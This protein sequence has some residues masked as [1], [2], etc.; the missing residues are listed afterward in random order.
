MIAI[1]RLI[2][3]ETERRAWDPVAWLGIAVWGLAAAK[4]LLHTAYFDGEFLA[5]VRRR[6]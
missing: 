4:K 3:G 2:A 6:S 5:Y 1:G